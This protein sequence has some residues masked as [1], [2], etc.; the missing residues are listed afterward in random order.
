MVVGFVRDAPKNI[1][2]G[3]IRGIVQDELIRSA[4]AAFIQQFDYEPHSVAVAP[5]RVELLGNHTDYNEGFVLTSAIDR[6]I[7]IAGSARE[8]PQVRVASGDFG[9]VRFAPEKPVS[10]PE[11]RWADYVMGIVEELQQSGV[12]MGGFDAAIVSTVPLGAGVSS[13]AALLLA[14]AK[15]C[16]ALYPDVLDFDPMGIAKLARR[17]ENNFVGAP[18]GL[19][20]QFSSA[21]GKAGHALF[22]D[23]RSLEW[24]AVPLPEKEIAILIADSGVKHALAAGGGYTERRAQCEEAARVLTGGASDK[25]RDV[26]REV[27]EE[28][29][30]TLDSTLEKRARHIIYENWRVQMGAEALE[31]GNWAA[32]GETLS[33]THESCRRFFENSCE[34]VDTLVELAQAQTGVYGAKLTGGGWG[35]CAVILHDPA[36]TASLCEAITV[37]YEKKYGKRPSLIPT[38]ASAGAE[39]FRL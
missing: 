6:G 37:G 15:L 14:T 17:A 35:G 32:F 27:F 16:L 8:V 38:I 21:F 13:S 10:D 26:S 1:F 28:K 33:N 22:L 39:S 3:T 7:A 24:R 9:M 19:L 36:I 30:A 34:E 20:D 11:A 5:G 23:C 25:L 2:W 12:T 4:H 18:V 31:N 29:A